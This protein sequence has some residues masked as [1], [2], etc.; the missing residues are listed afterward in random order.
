MSVHLVCVLAYDDEIIPT[1]LDHR[2]ICM[3]PSFT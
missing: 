3:A 2:L 1:T